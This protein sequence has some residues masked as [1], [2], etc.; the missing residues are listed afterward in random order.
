[1]TWHL[2]DSLLGLILAAC[3]PHYTA[4]LVPVTPIP[5]KGLPLSAEH[6]AAFDNVASNRQWRLGWFSLHRAIDDVQ[7][8]CII[9]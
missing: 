6:A 3:R 9:M 4:G 8:T 2:A 7:A 5:L 1:M